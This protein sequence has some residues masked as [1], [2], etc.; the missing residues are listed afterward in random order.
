MRMAFLLALGVVTACGT[1]APLASG[2]VAD[3]ASSDAQSQADA[4]DTVAVDAPTV[5]ADTIPTGDAPPRNPACSPP[6]TTSKGQQV[7]WKGYAKGNLTFTCNACPTG[8]PEIQGSW[9]LVDGETDDPSVPF[10]D[11]AKE[12]IQF[13]GNT[14][15]D[16]LH[17]PDHDVM[18]DQT[19]SGWYFCADKAELPSKHHVFV[20]QSAAPDG[21]FNNHAGDAFGADVLMAGPNILVLDMY[22]GIAGNNLGPYHYCRI[23]STVNGN[24][25]TDPFAK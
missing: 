21:A 12:V 11:G 9:R 8:D 2:G 1:P 20:L 25:C 7:P 18:T 19:T 23:G 15:T 14:F 13:D 10:S 4:P 5:T 24:A 16:H 6:A 3:A 17:Q 22:D